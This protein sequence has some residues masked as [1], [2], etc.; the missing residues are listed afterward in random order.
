MISFYCAGCGTLLN[1]PDQAAGK[2]GNC[3]HCN[4]VCTAPNPVRTL[5]AQTRTAIAE[6]PTSQGLLMPTT[7]SHQPPAVQTRGGAVGRPAPPPVLQ[8]RPIVQAAVPAVAPA[9]TPATQPIAPPPQT[10]VQPVI[11]VVVN[12]NSSASASARA[13]AVAGG[14]MW[15]TISV[16]SA[17]LVLSI[18]A[19][20]F[21]YTPSLS[22]LAVPT[23]SIAIILSLL[24]LVIS[25]FVGRGMARSIVAGVL[26]I[27]AISMAPAAV[28]RP[29]APRPAI[30]P[31]VIPVAEAAEPAIEPP[32]SEPAEPTATN[33]IPIDQAPASETP[34]AE[35]EAD[36]PVNEK[37]H[38][39]T[40]ASGHTTEAE[41]L[42]AVGGKAKLRK[43]DGKVVTVPIDKL[44][45]EDQEYLRKI[46]KK[47]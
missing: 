39:W 4:Q 2:T 14:G 1:V 15:S 10:V 21:A 26:S 25:L 16:A 38:T 40:S 22:W 24:G 12:A 27:V 45:A 35:L 37:M 31:P 5:L 18:V 47:R 42:S 34:P 36:L 20:T 32:V 29:P 3:P 8:T 41:F 30:V 43:V 9:V 46:Q 6:R 23:A 7:D 17:A 19:I 44:S 28:N 33:P 13:T 11:N